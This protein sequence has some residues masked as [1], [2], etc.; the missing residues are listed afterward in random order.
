MENFKEIKASEIK[1]SPVK[2]FSKDWSLITAGDENGY[3]TMTA[4]W[5]GVG[6]LW[7]KDVCFI[8]VRPQR[9][10]YEFIEKNEFFTVSFYNEEYKKALSFCGSKSGRDYDKA[11][12]TGLTPMFVDGTTTFEQAK[13]TVICR[14]I[15]YQ[16]MKPDG[17]IDKSIDKNYAAGDYHR[18]YVGEI[19]KVLERK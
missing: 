6:E 13:L 16:D 19:V 9:Y 10:T 3:N 7:N 17:F 12:E 18:V 14:K 15:A 5:G 4:S 11:K 2:L 8:F 1:E